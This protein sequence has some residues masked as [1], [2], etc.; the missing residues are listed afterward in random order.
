MFDMP[1]NPMYSMAPT[2]PPGLQGIPYTLGPIVAGITG[3]VA[4]PYVPQ[5]MATFDATMASQV[6]NPL[7]KS[8]MGT[9]YSQLGQQ[10]A[11]TMGDL[12][13]VQRMGGAAG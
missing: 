4:R 3:G 2:T 9:M 6:N 8:M 5:N 12:K 7:Y 10:I 1:V 11:T 13:F